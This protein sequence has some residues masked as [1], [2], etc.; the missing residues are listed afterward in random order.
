MALM[1]SCVNRGGAN[2]EEAKD[3][4]NHAM[5]VDDAKVE[6]E[7][8]EETGMGSG[9]AESVGDFVREAA[10]AS[11][12]EIELGRYAQQNASNPR[13]KNFGA[14]MVRDHTRASEELRKVATEKNIEI[15]SDL[16]DKHRNKIEDLMKKTGADFD[17]EYIKE[18]VDDHEKDVDLFRE[19]AENGNDP[20]VSAFA[21]KTLQVLHIHHDSA[22]LIKDA[23]DK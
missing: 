16:E 12:M 13:V 8:T 14:M 5:L 19:Q 6:G 15:P 7:E 11:M 23:I 3:M 21:G 18:M 17:E 2:N 9:N 1:V 10:S 22:K 20:D 4:D